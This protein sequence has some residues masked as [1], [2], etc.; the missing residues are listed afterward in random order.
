[1]YNAIARKRVSVDDFVK[2]VILL[3]QLSSPTQ[4]EEHIYTIYKFKSYTFYIVGN[5]HALITFLSSPMG[6]VI[7][8]KTL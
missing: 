7:I 8:L 6:H 2:L 4:V 5:S 1:V 3:R